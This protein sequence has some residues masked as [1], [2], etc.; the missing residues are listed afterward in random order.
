MIL[1][2]VVE[3]TLRKLSF[4]SGPDSVSKIISFTTSC[5][6]SRYFMSV[7]YIANANSIYNV[8][9]IY[10]FVLVPLCMNYFI[11]YRYNVLTFMPIFVAGKGKQSNEHQVP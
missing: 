4:R 2:L 10:T 11:F 1:L 3:D 5:S 7:I 9:Q 6:V 8:R